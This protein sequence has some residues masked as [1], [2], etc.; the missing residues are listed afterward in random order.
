AS[1]R[2]R[3]MA[4]RAALGAARLRIVKQLLT[5]SVLL[6]FVGATAGLLFA[7]GALRL[8]VMMGQNS[9]PRADEINLDSWVLLFSILIAVLVGILFGLAPAWQVTRPEL[10]DSLKDTARGAIGTRGRL[11]QSLAVAQVSLTLLLLVGAGLLLR[12]FYQLQ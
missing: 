8:M 12:S 9:I 6:A 10:Q 2:Q 11:R 3:E 1:G 7:Y 4:V 5:E